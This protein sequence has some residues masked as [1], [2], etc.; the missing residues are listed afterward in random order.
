M[1]KLIII[2][3]IILFF[4]LF[5]QEERAQYDSA[6]VKVW[7]LREDIRHYFPDGKNGI[8]EMQGWTLEQWAAEFG[9][10]E[11]K[12]LKKYNKQAQKEYIY[13]KYLPIEKAL[14][15]VSSREYTDEYNCVNFSIDLKEELKKEGI[16]SV[17][18]TGNSTLGY[19]R[20][21]AI[22][23]EPITGDILKSDNYNSILLSKNK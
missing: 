19:H 10:K 4:P 11:Y 2:L 3:I 14:N 15:N 23:F 21:I 16:S 6:L 1:K 7:N 17:M 22:E 20:W 12:S 9:W 13:E 18:I 5:Q 8:G